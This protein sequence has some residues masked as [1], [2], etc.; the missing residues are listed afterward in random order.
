MEEKG[1]VNCIDRNR[2]CLF[3]AMHIPINEPK[4][5]ISATAAKNAAYLSSQR[6]RTYCF[7]A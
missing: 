1:E 3:Q 4:L 2:N 5:Q 7:D 6:G